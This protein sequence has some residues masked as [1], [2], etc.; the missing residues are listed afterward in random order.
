[1]CIR[2]RVYPTWVTTTTGNLPQKTSSTKLSFVPSTGVLSANGV[3]LTGN[4]GTVTSFA[5]TGTVNGI[6]LTGGTITTTGT[7]TLGGTLSGVSLATQVTG[8]L[9]VTNLN[10][11]TSA[12]SSTFWRGDGTWAAAS[13]TPAGSTTQVQYN[14]SGS[15]AGSANFTFDGTNVLV[16]GTV[17]GGSDERFKKNWREVIPGFIEKLS[18]VKSGIYDR[19]DLDLTQPGVSAQSLQE[20]L[21]EAVLS[22]QNGMLSVNYG[23]AALLSAV[24]LAKEIVALR[25]EIKLLKGIK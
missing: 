15:F 18:Q 22:D 14:S 13:A 9:P 11:G 10:S 17:S 6:T 25:K 16:A 23:G 21:P 12:S 1:M 8:N 3:A 24:E 5:T 2:D 7:I 20:V 19:T 4:T